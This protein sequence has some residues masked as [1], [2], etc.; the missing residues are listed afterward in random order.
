[1]IKP[2]SSIEKGWGESS[3][4]FKVGSSR[5]T[6]IVESFKKIELGSGGLSKEIR[7]YQI[8]TGIELICEIEANSE[9]T[10]GY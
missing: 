8:F 2:I 4:Y 5:V 9:L 3:T 1:M 7:V 10:I 6:K